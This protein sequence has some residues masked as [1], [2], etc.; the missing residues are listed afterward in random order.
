MLC[1]SPEVASMLERGKFFRK[2][3][4]SNVAHVLCD[5]AATV[6]LQIVLIAVQLLYWEDLGR[7]P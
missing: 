6:F 5:R 3:N 1:I 7:M 2:P 4:Q